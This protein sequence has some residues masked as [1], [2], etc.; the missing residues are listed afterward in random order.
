[1]KSLRYTMSCSLYIINY[2]CTKNLYQVNCMRIDYWYVMTNLHCDVICFQ[3]FLLSV[4][5]NLY[6]TIYNEFATSSI[7][8]MAVYW[9]PNSLKHDKIDSAV[10]VLSCNLSIIHVHLFDFKRNE[11]AFSC[12][13][14]ALYHRM[15]QLTSFVLILCYFIIL[16]FR[17]A[18]AYKQRH[19]FLII[20][21]NI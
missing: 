7:L 15:Y 8:S 4:R 10:F 17:Y 11:L 20:I 13:L 18:E 16:I 5:H 6:I 3:L 14:Y 1:M 9:W 21:I 19:V 12:L 2:K